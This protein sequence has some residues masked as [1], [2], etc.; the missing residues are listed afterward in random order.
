VGAVT[1]FTGLFGGAACC[2]L[3]LASASIGIGA[4]GLASL[5]ALHAPLF[6]VAALAVAGG[7]YLYFKRESA[8]TLES[9]CEPP[10]RT[11]PAVLALATALI[12]LSGIWP[13]IEAPLM[14]SLEQ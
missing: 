10:A 12:I 7:W 11:T 1:G 9:N 3:P 14:R 13:F 6:A 8:C 5:S 2:V 4:S